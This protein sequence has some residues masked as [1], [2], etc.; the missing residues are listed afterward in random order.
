MDN[1]KNFNPTIQ[2]AGMQP[3]GTGQPS[4]MVIIGVIIVLLIAAGA[5]YWWL[6]IRSASAPLPQPPAGIPES[7]SQNV[8]P[9]D[10]SSAVI[11]Q[12]IQAIEVNNTDADF[13]EVDNDLKQL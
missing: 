9:E 6:Y 5:G 2:P 4:K 1:I 11:N 13:Q 3:V 10:D 7:S 12:E 8:I